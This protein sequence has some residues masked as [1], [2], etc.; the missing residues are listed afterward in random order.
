MTNIEFRTISKNVITP[1]LI[2]KKCPI[3]NEC[4]HPE[5]ICGVYK[6]CA[7]YKYHQMGIELNKYL[8]KN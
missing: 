2:D 6:E 4:K 7:G 8:G 5:Y 1:G 3:E